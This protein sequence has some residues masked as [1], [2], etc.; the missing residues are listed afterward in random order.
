VTVPLSVLVGLLG[1]G[2]A[3]AAEVITVENRYV[4]GWP[5]LTVRA[6]PSA[7]AESLGSLPFGQ[8]VAVATRPALEV[9]EGTLAG[10]WV[11][12]RSGVLRGF[13]FDA[14][15]LDLPGPPAGC[16]AFDDWAARWEPDGPTVVERLDDPESGARI[17]RRVQG[18]SDGQERVWESGGEGR[19][20]ELWLPDVRLA[21]AW[22]AARR[23]DLRLE[24]INQ[25]GWP[26]RGDNLPGV[27]VRWSAEQVEVGPRQAGEV[28]VSLEQQSGGTVVRWREE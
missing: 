20:G 17:E 28:W 18:Y 22:L 8:A 12:V 11:E 25:R 9:R 21:Q 2:P 3:V 6:A 15:L 10:A 4:V 1:G 5:G 16:R 13:V 24:P 23:C 7:G 14:F 26:P 27:R 19:W